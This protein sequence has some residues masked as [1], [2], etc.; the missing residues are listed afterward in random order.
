LTLWGIDTVFSAGYSDYD[1]TRK[2]T[3]RLFRFDITSSAPD[4]VPLETPSQLFGDDNWILEYVSIRDFSN[5]AANASGIFPFARSREKIEGYY[6]ALDAQVLDTVRV[7]AGVRQEDTTIEADAWGGNTEPGT[8]NQ[9]SND[10]TDSL[11]AASVTWE[12]I[13]NMQL[14]FAYSETVNRPSLLEITGSTLRNPED[15]N[16]YRGNVFLQPADLTNYDA[17]WEWYFGNADE[18]SVGLFYKEFDNPI[19][20][21]KIQAQGDIFTW[22]NADSAEL[23]GIEFDVRKELPLGEWLSLD[24]VWNG[25]NIAVNASYIDSEVTLLGSGETAAD[26]PLTGGRQ[27]APLFSNKRKMTGQSDWLGNLLLSY[28]DYDL[29]VTGSI[30]YNYTDERIIL[31]GDNNAP[32][33][34]EEGR[35]VVDVLF[36]YEIPWKNYDFEFEAKAGNIFDAKVEW[37][38]GGLSYE[39]WRPGVNYS[40]GLRATF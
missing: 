39:N 30:L 16:L 37:T 31:V 6:G 14:R 1:R 32:D 8:E 35:G 3:D 17:R 25:F 15:Q 13:E 26:V 9:V 19:E 38:Q 21:A 4:Y 28:V 12:F 34:V 7:Q 5:S 22:F 18:M 36:K 33:I 27:I 29:G 11:P 23:R 24:P 20:L 10:Y 2:N 40:I